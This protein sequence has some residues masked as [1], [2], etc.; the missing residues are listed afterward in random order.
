M[1]NEIR[2]EG[3]T[4]TLTRVFAAPPADVFDAWVQTSKIEQWW[5][6]AM[7]TAVKST[8]EPEVG[9]KF[10]HRMTLEGVGDMD[11]NACFTVYDPPRRLAYVTPEGP[12]SPAMTV[13]VD[14]VAEGDGTRVTLVH[15]GLPDE[16]TPHVRLGWGAGMDKLAQ[17]LE[18]GTVVR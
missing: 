15:S 17:F 9:G 6:C 18:T 11:M 10:D 2:V 5:G 4:L 16:Y 1:S 8:I 14:F 12:S 3:D 13:T 7:T